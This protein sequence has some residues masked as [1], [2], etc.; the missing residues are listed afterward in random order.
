M[1][2]FYFAAIEKIYP[3]VYEF[4]KPKDPSKVKNGAQ[5]GAAAAGPSGK[6]EQVEFFENGV[7]K[8]KKTN[9]NS[10]QKA[11]RSKVG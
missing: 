2:T 7:R 5:N 6:S 4:K 8:T 10:S 1:T 11:A 9:P 3:M